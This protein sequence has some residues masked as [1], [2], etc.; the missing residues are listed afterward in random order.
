MEEG[1]REGDMREGERREGEGRVGER[2]S[3]P[4][5]P[6]NNNVTPRGLE[7]VSVALNP[8]Q[9]TRGGQRCV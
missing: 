8:S 6:F 1:K 2:I 5:P 4:F 7:V 3:P 9:L